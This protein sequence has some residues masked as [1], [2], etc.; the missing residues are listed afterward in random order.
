MVLLEG[1]AAAYIT[2]PT[3]AWPDL[4]SRSSQNIFRPLLLFFFP[5][6]LS[7]YT[8]QTFSN[9]PPSQSLPFYFAL[10]SLQFSSPW[11]IGAIYRIPNYVLA[12][13]PLSSK[14]HIWLQFYQIV[15]AVC[16]YSWNLESRPLRRETRDPAIDSIS[17]CPTPLPLLPWQAYKRSSTVGCDRVFQS[18]KEWQESVIWNRSGNSRFNFDC[19]HLTED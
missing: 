7:W 16:L 5:F 8:L 13:C 10:V 12:P 15:V 1:G 18:F 17:R 11:S 19:P 3:T 4:F 6:Q 2:T 9:L 14:L